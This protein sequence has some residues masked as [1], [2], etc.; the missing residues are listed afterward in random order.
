MPRPTLLRLHAATGALALV[1]ILGFQA[2]TVLVEAFGSPTAIAAVKQAIAWSLLALVPAL[3][4]AGITGRSLGR[5]WRLPAVA[6][7]QRR[8]ALAAANGLLILAPA[9]IAL[10]R[11]SAQG[12][13][14]PLFTAIQATELAAGLVNVVLLGLNMKDGLALRARASSPGLAS[15]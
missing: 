9:A 10:A 8:M 7:K 4:T 14:G 5:G 13:F 12:S 2:A 11:L 1:M 15:R 3:A 6:A